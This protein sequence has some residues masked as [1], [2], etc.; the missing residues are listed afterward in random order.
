MLNLS[1]TTI[2]VPTY[3]RPDICNRFI[4]S[5]KYD[6]NIVVVAQSHS[7][8]IIKKDNVRVIK[9]NQMPLTNAYNLG[10]MISTEYFN[11]ECFLF[12]D[13]DVI[14]CD[15]T[16]I[17]NNIYDLLNKK[18][19]GLVSISRIINNKNTKDN[20]IQSDFV[21]KGGGWF[22][23]RDKFNQ[24]QGF[25]PNNSVDEW[26]IC[27][28]LYINGYLNYR[29]QTAYAYHKQG[30]KG[31]YKQSIAENNNIGKSDNWLSNWID[32]N[33]VNVSGYEYLEANSKF[34]KKAKLLHKQ[35]YDNILRQERL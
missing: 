15:E 17:G 2:I 18:T 1:N 32:G 8:D 25:T 9:C 23:S 5:V 24:V 34:N 10:A 33:I 20:H 7:E 28:K 3:K 31:G 35:N 19:T 22:V 4:D 6:I 29:T 16:I 21:Y 30:S 14:F 27:C 12:T 11:T 26:D 13:D